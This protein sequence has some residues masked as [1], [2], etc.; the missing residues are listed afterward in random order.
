MQTETH[1]KFGRIILARYLGGYDDLVSGPKNLLT[2][3]TVLPDKKYNKG[4]RFGTVLL[5]RWSLHGIRNIDA[6]IEAGKNAPDWVRYD[7]EH[8]TLIRCL[9]MS[10]YW[11]DLFNFVIHPS[12]PSSWDFKY[13]PDQV[14]KILTF[15]T[16]SDPA[17]IEDVLKRMVDEHPRLEDL[18]MTMLEEYMDLPDRTGEYLKRVLQL[19]N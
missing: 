1:K 2:N 12:R 5:H 10:H 8:D 11:L 13:I 15:G 14:P 19:Y 4:T 7:K 3:W 17:G 16:V 6:T 18:L 9:I